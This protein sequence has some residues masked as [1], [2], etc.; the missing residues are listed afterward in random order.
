MIKTVK[1]SAL[2]LVVA[3]LLVSVVLVAC[4][5]KGEFTPVEA[6]ASGKDIIGN[7]GSVVR[8]DNYF[9][10]VNGYQSSADVSN[11]YDDEIRVG[12]IVRVKVEDIEEM[13][14]VYES[15]LSSS[16]ISEKIAELVEENVEIVVPYYY[17]SAN[18][19]VTALNGIYI[20]KVGGAERLYITTPCQDKTANGA[21]LTNQLTLM[22]FKLDGSDVQTHY[23]FPSNS[24]QIMLTAT[25]DVVYATYVNG[26]VMGC[27]NVN[28]GAEVLAEVKEISSAN[29]SKIND[30]K[31]Y[32]FFLDEDGAICRYTAGA[33][34][35]E[36]LVANADNEK[37]T[38]TIKSV[39]KDTVYYTVANTDESY[40][41]N[42]T[43]YY[44]N[45]VATDNVVSLQGL[46]AG[47]YYCWNGKVVYVKS[48]N[49]VA[50]KTLYSLVIVSGNANTAETNVTIL[51]KE[52]NASTITFVKL[53][54]D[55]LFYTKNSVTYWVDLAV[56]FDA[57]VANSNAEVTE[58]VYGY[59]M[60]TTATGWSTPDT[61]GE[62]TFTLGSSSVTVTKFDRDSLTNSKSVN[63]TLLQPVEEEA[64]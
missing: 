34:A 36:V 63:L 43:L 18:T 12:Q 61:I 57:R 47:T 29:F 11:G 64:E 2:L 26:T 23:T 22:S 20:F 8:Y 59:S 30:S 41:D 35:H 33:S 7:G 42:L 62:Y 51:D 52:D 4:Q 6:P 9:Y 17:Y 19:T 38:Y 10:Y 31:G 44:T 3:L 15:D 25:S 14:K 60:S 37:I 21:S 13:L 5:P 28:T 16:K 39:N 56:A 58:N 46:P 53:E 48:D 1:K 40:K 24:M 45:A 54:G 27:I 55:V 50:N 49:K 32:I